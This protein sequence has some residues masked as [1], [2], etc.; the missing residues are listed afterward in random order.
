MR[1]P[2]MSHSFSAEICAICARLSI[3]TI[4]EYRITLGA[5]LQITA[6][7][8]KNNVKKRIIFRILQKEAYLHTAISAGY[9]IL[10]IPED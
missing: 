5:S 3:T 2:K 7:V 8:S 4:S 6:A 1:L 9:A 10:Q